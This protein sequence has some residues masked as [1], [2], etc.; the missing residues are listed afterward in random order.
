MF[1]Q[2]PS[3]YSC[4]RTIRITPSLLLSYFRQLNKDIHLQVT[5]IPGLLT[6]HDGESNFG[7]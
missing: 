6:R 1:K 5:D 7:S 4:H 3:S 2:L